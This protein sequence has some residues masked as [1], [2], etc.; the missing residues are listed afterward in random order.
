MF[1]GEPV[2]HVTPAA[3]VFLPMFLVSPS[4]KHQKGVQPFLL[5]THQGVTVNSPLSLFL[6]LVNLWP[7]DP[8]NLSQWLLKCHRVNKGQTILANVCVWQEG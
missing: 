7:R 5:L 2:W 8:F 1:L 3:E 6:C 4:P